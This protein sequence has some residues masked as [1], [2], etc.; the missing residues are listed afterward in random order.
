[1][2][3]TI[4]YVVHALWLWISK[5]AV[6]VHPT[7]PTN[8]INHNRIEFYPWRANNYDNYNVMLLLYIHMNKYDSNSKHVG[9]LWF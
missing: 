1:M 6:S 7:H 2:R 8:K 3:Y 4:P 5:F 9:T